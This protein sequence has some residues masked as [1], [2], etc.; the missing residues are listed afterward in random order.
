MGA[1]LH[2]LNLRLFPEQL[3][4]IVNH[5]EDR[6]IVL[7]AGLV[8]VLAPLVPQLG[9][10]EHYVVIGDGDTSALEGGRAAVH[11]YDELLAAQEPGYEWPEIDERAAAAMC[12]TSGTTGN[13][14]GVVYSH[15]STF[16]HSLGT[17][18]AGAGAYT[19]RDRMLPVVPMF[20]AERV[21]QAVLGVAGRERSAAARALRAVGAAR[22]ADRRGATHD[23]GRRCRPSGTTCCTTRRRIPS[24]S[25]RSTRSSSAAPRCPVR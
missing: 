1:V 7:E 17:G 4:F 6:V 2:T 15:R 18:L 21:G 3:A 10:V 11:R 13:P 19:D 24:T 20:H 16:L 14:K 25:R 8:P 5:A 9:T 23:R 12:Y 22:G